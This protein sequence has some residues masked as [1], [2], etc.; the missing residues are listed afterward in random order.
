MPTNIICQRCQCINEAYATTCQRCGARFCPHCKMVIDSPNAR[1]CP[2]CG[3]ADLSFK[4]GKYAGST[5]VAPGVSAAPTG[6]NYCS[7]C[8]SRVEPGVKKCP[9]CGRLGTLVTQTPHQGYGAMEPAHRGMEQAYAP[10]PEPEEITTQKVCSKCGTP[11]PPGSSLCP[12]H[13][14]FGGGSTLKQG[15]AARDTSVEA[16]AYRRMAARG[17]E[18]AEQTRG[19]PHRTPPEK[20]YPQMVSGQA[21]PSEGMPMEA[22]PES[23]ELRTCPN[24]GSPVPDRSKVCPHCGNN[25]LP[26]QKGRP[27]MKAEEFYRSRESTA[28]AYPTP[29]AAPYPLPYPEYGPPADPYYGQPALQPYE[30]NYPVSSSGFIEEIYPPDEKKKGGK[31]KKSQEAEYYKDAARRPRKSPW[32]MLL[33]LLALTGVIIIAAVLI[34]DML[35]APAPIT[36]LP[37]NP[38]PGV[39][40]TS[41]PVISNIQFSDIDE[42]SATVTWTTDKEANSIVI[43]CLEGGDLCENAKDDTLVQNHSMKLTGLEKGQSYHITVKSMV[44]DVD[45]SQDAP[46]LL[47]LANE[48]D[49]IPP[50]I[51]AVAAKNITSSSATITWTTDEDATSQVEY[52]TS[53]SYGTLQPEQ[54]DTTML[55]THSVTLNG[56]PAG[57]TFHFRVTSR[58]AAGNEKSSSDYPFTTSSQQS[59]SGIGIGTIAPDFTLLCNDGSELTLSALRGKKVI[60]NFWSLNCSYCEIEMPF[61]QQVHDERSDVE[62]LAVCGP[63]MGTVNEP[64]VGNYLSTNDFTILVPLDTSGFVGL[65]YDVTDGVPVTFFLDSSGIIRNFKDGAFISGAD[66]IESMLD[67]Y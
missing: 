27:I 2:H 50:I 47:I 14:K 5:Y 22:H 13:G 57:T 19:Q 33:A 53:A 8:G 56:L 30:E 7:N 16:E 40:V 6:Q 60:L 26:A 39:V 65:S 35:K 64:V 52:G 18:A 3:K 58:D 11:I 61:L 41:A 25:R 62:V 43:Y 42:T 59:S 24:C 32:P 28:Q 49:T 36:T 17:T 66:D 12:I 48:Q 9:Y 23:P 31:G 51:S 4:P 34:M 54:E 55:T 29:Y 44:D 21:M 20:T 67:S 45:A 1:V 63:Q 38:N 15:F 46:G 37:G 10:A